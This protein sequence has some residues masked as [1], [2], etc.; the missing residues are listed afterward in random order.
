ME[1]S[2]STFF[3]L[4]LILL[5]AVALLT[6]FVMGKTLAQIPPRQV[7]AVAVGFTIF[8]LT[9]LRTTIGLYILVFS[10]LLSPEISIMETAARDVTVRVDDFLLLILGFTWFAKT[11]MNKE[12]ALLQSSPLSA[13]IFAYIAVC[14]FSTALGVCRGNVSTMSGFFFVLKFFE[15]FLV[16]FMV[17]NTVNT[18]EQA[19]NFIIAILVTCAITAMYGI[20]Q[21][22]AGVRVSAPFE[23]ESG[24]PGTFGGY[25]V[26]I[27]ALVLS[28]MIYTETLKYKV[29]FGG[30]AGLITVPLLYTL[31]RASFLAFVPMF[32]VFFMFSRRRRFLAFLLAMIVVISPFF[33]PYLGDVFDRIAYTY[34]SGEL[35]P[36]SAE[37]VESYKRI[38]TSDWPQRP[39]FGYGVT[40][41]GFIDGQF[42]RALAETGILGLF[43]FLW[44]LL[45]IYRMAIRTYHE[46]PHRLDQIVSLGFVAGYIGLLFHA[47]TANTFIIV[48]IMEPF[49]F[50]AGIVAMMYE[51]M[52]LP[53]EAVAEEMAS[54]Q[55]T[56]FGDTVT[57]ADATSGGV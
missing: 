34:S 11:A 54:P 55:S 53:D 1:S 25:L 16:Y 45:R 14:A 22:G 2:A 23:G 49:W 17:L 31:S 44:L 4:L 39:V 47:L 41:R 28:F 50:L 21:I 35:D 26:L 10:M 7:V 57:Q 24:E 32:A 8:I 51:T 12:L 36:S 56:P 9:F 38:L 30:L 37:R 29:L 6:V 3:R 27:L 42:F 48:R 20:S 5:A 13:P 18:R 46:S 43:C 40:G 19:R 15:Y 52:H 33:V